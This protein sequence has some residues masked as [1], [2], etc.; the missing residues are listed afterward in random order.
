MA[1]T[2]GMS[3]SAAMSSVRARHLPARAHLPARS[4][5][6]PLISLKPLIRRGGVRR[7]SSSRRRLVSARAAQ[8]SDEEVSGVVGGLGKGNADV[9]RILGFRQT[10]GAEAE[11]VPKWQVMVQLSKPGTWVPVV[12]GVL[13]GAAAS[14]N[15]HWIEG[16]PRDVSQSLACIILSGP[17]LTGFT[18]TINDWYDREID[19]INEP[20]RPIPSG[21]VTGTDV[22][23]QAIGLLVLGFAIAINLDQA[24]GH[25]FPTLTC[26]AIFGTIISY[27]Y[28][29]PPFKLKANG[30]QGTYALGAS[31]IALPWWAGQAL[32]GELTLEIM[33]VTLMYSVAGLGIAI[34]NDFKSI[35]GDR[36]LGLKSLPVQ[37][38]VDTAKYITVGTIDGFQLL[39]AAW[40]FGIGEKWYGLAL[41]GL[42]VPQVVA[43]IRYFIPDPI[44]NDVKYQASAQPFLVLGILTTAFA[45]GHNPYH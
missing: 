37:F 32:F 35:E 10:D 11:E 15:F 31:Y 16:F 38:G 13:C 28:S 2:A 7:D 6:K 25:E 17:C 36:E 30:W 27:M 39:V 19:A 21:R 40:L 41:L 4:L 12:W 5:C 43:Q 34:V 20:N 45:V 26:I 29:A 8:E 18:Q 23:I 3:S 1:F 33:L 42:I 9:Q 44:K 22:A 14:G 24:R